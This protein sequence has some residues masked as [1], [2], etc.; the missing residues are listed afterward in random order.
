MRVNCKALR[1]EN[2]Q[3][4]A[5]LQAAQGVTRKSLNQHV[6]Q[7]KAR[8]EDLVKELETARVENAKLLTTVAALEESAKGGAQ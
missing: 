4:R 8:N 6:Q 7:L 5:Q 1:A 2:L 3:L